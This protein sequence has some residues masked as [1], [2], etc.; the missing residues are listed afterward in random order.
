[1]IETSRSTE[2]SG[3]PIAHAPS[4]IPMIPAT[5]GIHQPRTW[6]RDNAMETSKIP[7]ISRYHATK[8]ESTTNVG[9]GHT[10]APMPAAM[11]RVPPM[12]AI[13]RQPP[14]STAAS[15]YCVTPP[16]QNA[17]AIRIAQTEIET[18]RNDST[19]KPSSNHRM[20]E[21]SHSHHVLAYACATARS[22]SGDNVMRMPMPTIPSAHSACRGGRVHLRIMTESWPGRSHPADSLG[23]VASSGPP[24]FFPHGRYRR[25]IRLVARH[26]GV[27][28][29]GLEDDQH[30]FTVTLHHDGTHVQSVASR[31]VRAPWSTCAAAAAPLRALADTPLSDRCVAVTRGTESAHHCT[32]QLD[33]AGLAIA[34][35]ARVLAGGADRRQYDAVVPFGL[36]DGEEHI[37]TLERDGAPCLEWVVRAGAIVAPSP[38]ADAPPGFARWADATLTPDDAEAAVVLRRAGNIGMS[39]GLDLDQYATLADMPG[40]SPV[41][42]SMQPDRAPVAFRNRGLIRD[43]D[44]RPDAMLAEGPDG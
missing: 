34:H 12:T 40:L 33:L 9:S 7:R 27:V 6:V 2:R 41:C 37:V 25:R 17:T 42:W 38:Y 23:L 15:A 39:R 31:S 4:A 3:L 1:M 19:T 18:G 10:S 26:P 11:A 13:H 44:D 8:I 20:P 14:S 30:Y 21:T 16:S 28:E 32:H 24:T 29:G 5:S 43:Y 35:A 22:S 36:L